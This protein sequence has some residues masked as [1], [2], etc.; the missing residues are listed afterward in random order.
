MSDFDESDL[1]G[2]LAGLRLAEPSVA[3]ENGVQI[4]ATYAHVMAPF[5]LAFKEALPGKP[6][7]APWCSAP[8]GLAV[9]IRAEIVIPKTFAMPNWYDRPN[10]IWW[11]VTLLR[12]RVSQLARVPVVS[13]IAFH[14]VPQTSESVVR[15]WPI[16]VEK[17]H[18]LLEDQPREEATTEDLQWL[19]A[20]WLRGG[21]I[22]GRSEEFNVLAQSFSDAQR[23]RSPALA[24][25][26]LWSALEG[27][28]SP[29]RTELRFR[30]S[31]LIAAYLE[32][33]GIGR[34][35]L[36]RDVARL[37]DARSS[38]AHGT[39]RQPVQEVRDTYSLVRRILI[40]IIESGAAPTRDELEARLFGVS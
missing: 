10:T 27:M 23:A 36:Q 33:P 14:D 32:P 29:A 18:L 15:F 5:L 38:V 30:V 4:R 3:L 16:E 39:S 24:L 13:N 35:S 12:L 22:A 2:G 19:A 40:F 9:D 7:P 26:S 25:L 31:S 20:N 21:R 34:Q 11:T 1:Y 6:H 17:S 8:G 28:F 37:Y